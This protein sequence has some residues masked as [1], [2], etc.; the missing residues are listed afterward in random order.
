MQTGIQIG[1]R[2]EILAGLNEGDQVIVRGLL[3][4]KDGRKVRIVNTDDLKTDQTVSVT[5]SQS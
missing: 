3:R 2:I 4:I 1:D 5:P